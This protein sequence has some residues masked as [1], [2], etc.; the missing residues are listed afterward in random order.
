[1]KL[2]LAADGGEYTRKALDFIL[3]HDRLL[4]SEREL[5]VIHVQMSLPAGFNVMM[6]FDKAR[7]LHTIE[8][9]KIFKPIRSFLDKH[10]VKYRCLTAIGPIVKE[11]IDAAK[12]EHVHLIVMGTRGRDLLGRALMGSVAQKV[13]AHSTVPVLLVK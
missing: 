8:A 5:V 3:A 9:E 4:G 6:G 13:V 12:T 7:E 1:M 11:I 10:T 2:L